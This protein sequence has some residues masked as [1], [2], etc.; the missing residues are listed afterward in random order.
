MRNARRANSTAD[1]RAKKPGLEFR[2]A[3]RPSDNIS[4]DNLRVWEL[5]DR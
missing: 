5:Q 2:A 1:F 4:F 3:G